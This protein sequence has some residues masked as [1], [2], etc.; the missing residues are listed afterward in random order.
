MGAS[1]AEEMNAAAENQRKAQADFEASIRSTLATAGIRTRTPAEIAQ[2]EREEA[3]R[4]QHHQEYLAELYKTGE[5]EIY[6]RACP[7]CGKVF[8]TT[9]PRRKYDDYYMCSRYIHR[10]NA[11]AA[12][13][14]ARHYV[15]CAICKKWFL[16]ARTGAMYCG[17]ACKQKAYRQRVTA[18]QSG[19]NDH[20]D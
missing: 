19:Q 18:N 7:A 9:N 2:A 13:K 15:E 17:A 10:Q 4:E 6:K 12:R 8:Y 3:E 14:Q 16:P 20:I 11:K 1:T 5:Y